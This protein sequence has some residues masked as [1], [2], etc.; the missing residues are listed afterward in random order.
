MILR[1]RGALWILLGLVLLFAAGYLA[2]HRRDGV[3][4]AQLALA[5]ERGFHPLKPVFHPKVKDRPRGAKAV[6]HLEADL[7]EESTAHVLNPQECPS[8]DVSR[9]TLL[10]ILPSDLGGECSVDVFESGGDW[11]A[12]CSLKVWVATD[13]PGSPRIER[14][15]LPAQSVRVGEIARGVA[16]RAR[17]WDILA[18]GSFGTERP[19]FELGVSRLQTEHLGWYALAESDTGMSRGRIHGGVRFSF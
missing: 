2:G 12:R 13:A 11:W 18:G 10:Q 15:P 19:G 9:G 14:G 7:P 5:V 16:S 1:A 17:R 6:I 4:P 3:D 8:V